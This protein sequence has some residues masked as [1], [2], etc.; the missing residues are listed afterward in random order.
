M[1]E[2]EIR[3]DILASTEQLEKELA[4]VD[5]KNS[6]H[7]ALRRTVYALV[8]AAAV[9]V[10]VASLFLPVL[11]IYGSSMAPTVEAGDI[12]VSLKKR[13]YLPGDVVALYYE[14]RIL[15]KRIVAGEFDTVELDADGNFRIN[16]TPLDE[17]YLAAK[18]FGDNTD[19]SFPFQV[20]EDSYFVCGD[21][22]KES[23]DSRSSSVGCI[24]SE[25]IV[26]EIVFSVWPWRRIGKI[27]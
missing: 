1:E 16:G 9:S 25:E 22:R 21:N 24:S 14:N 20:P 19:I 26:G 10:L 5:H 7:R 11:R 15:V 2:K 27:H 8:V 23:V 18:D 3:E 12:V 13:E 17:P 6:F 4:R